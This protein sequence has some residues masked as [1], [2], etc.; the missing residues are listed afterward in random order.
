MPIIII[1]RG[2]FSG[3]QTLAERV[4]HRLG[5]RCLSREVLVEAAAT[6]KVPEP[7]L[8]QFFDTRPGVWERLTQSRRLYLIF[9]QATMCE[10]A[11][12]G[13]LVYHGQ[14][15]HLLLPGISHVLKVRLIAPLTYRIQAVMER[16]GLGREAALQYIQRV[17]EERLQRMRY[18][19]NVDWRDPTLYDVVLNLEHMSLE[20]AADVVI[21]MAQHPEYQPTPTSTKAFQD[22]TLSCRVQ[23]AVA[24]HPTTRGVEVEVQADDG[25]VWVSGVVDEG[26]LQE[27]I[28]QISRT[29]PGVK[30]VISE[31]DFR[32]IFLHPG[33]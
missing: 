4:A 18:L 24:A 32:P 27:E 12:Q 11:R 22:L 16:Q 2:S 23:A 29:V 33:V 6:Y 13:N 19:F 9:L 5:A 25:V 8:A 20:T 21:Y 28:L 30:E 26:E 7:K 14:A 3:G 31:L 17:D 1:S 10:R 15:G